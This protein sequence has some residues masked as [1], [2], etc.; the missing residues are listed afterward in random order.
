MS[1]ESQKV[2]SLKVILEAWVPQVLYMLF[3]GIKEDL[4]EVQ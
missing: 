3:E 2:E 1:C 4:A